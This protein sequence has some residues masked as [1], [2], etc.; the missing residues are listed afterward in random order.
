MNKKIFIPFL[1]V[2]LLAAFI[3]ISSCQKDAKPVAP[4]V[5]YSFV[6]EFDSME[7]MI[8]Q[9]WVAK[10]NSRPLGTSTWATGQYSWSAS[11]GTI[12]GYP[13]A[14]TSHSG[15]DYVLCNYTAQADP[16]Q[17]Q[18]KGEASC[19]LISPAVP[20]KDGDIIKFWT[21]TL[22]NPATFKDRM[23]FRINPNNSSVEVGNDSNTVGDFTLRAIAINPDLTATGYPGGNPP[24]IGT[25]TG[26][27]W[28]QY[29]WTVSG[30]PIPKLGRFAFRYNTP[31]AGPA[32]SNG[33]GVAVDRVEF[34]S[35]YI[36]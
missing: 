8:Q 34:I 16:A 28:Q 23:E 7:A 15:I 4:K 24:P 14:S 19:W 21:R 31:D 22:D 3:I 30:S 26:T 10:N 32:G 12:S 27:G 20:M 5:D 25:S 9:G 2:A 35:K 29:I 11:C 1:G 6:Q 33:Q 36:P 17:G 18:P 13:G